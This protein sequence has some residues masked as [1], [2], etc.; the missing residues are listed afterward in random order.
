MTRK[1]PPHR[2]LLLTHAQVFLIVTIILLVI[3]LGSVVVLAYVNINTA[4]AFQ[5][6][7]VVT[8]LAN[9]QRKIIELH[10]ETNLVLRDRSTNV[11]LIEIKRASL[12]RHLEISE[13]EG[14]NNAKLI[15]TLRRIRY[16]LDQYDY[17][18]R[19]II[20]NPT[21]A[22]FRSSS[23]QFDSILGMLENE[24]QAL[25][26]N[27]ELRFFENIDDA[28]KQQRTSQ[29][30][31]ITIG[32][33]LL[34]FTVLF[35][36]S[37]R[38]SVSGEFQHAYDLLKEEVS[39]RRRAEEELRQQNEYFS[40]LH[41]TSLALMNR[42]DVSDLLE[43]IVSRAAQLMGTEDG[44]IYLMNA[45]KNVLERRVGV[46]LFSKSIG[47][48][49]KR[50]EGMAGQ[51]WQD[52]HSMVINDYPTWPYRAPTP[53][54]RENTIAAA[55]GAPLKSGSE[56]VGV[57]GLAFNRESGRIFSQSEVELLEGFAQLA[58]IALDN[59][60]LFAQADQRTMQIEA[61]YLADQELYKHLELDDVLKTL[62]D[63]AV[64]IL[65]IDKSVLIVWNDEKTMLYPKAAR[66]FRPE[67][68]ERMVFEPEQGLIGKVAMQKEP[69]VVKDTTS[70]TRVDWNITYPERIR[71]FM[72]VPIIVDDQVF[73]IFNVSYTEAQPFDEDDLR[74]VLALA[75]RGASAIKNASLYS[76]AQQAAML[77]E[78]QRLARELHDAVTQTLFSAGIIADV[79]PRLW[80]KDQD[81]ALKR[82]EELRELTRGALAEMRTLLWELRPTALSE[83]SL[84]ELLHQLGEVTVGRTRIPVSV[85]VKE[86]C[87]IPINVKIAFYRIAQEALN[88]IAKHA[89]ARHVKVD[90]QCAPDGV[91]LHIT[92][93][94]KGFDGKQLLPDN[95]GIRIMRERSEAVGADFNLESHVG[96]GTRIT[97]FWL[98][99]G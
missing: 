91:S 29:T 51:V 3:A 49:L 35:S 63:V 45:V 31:T 46:G 57:I 66:G 4:T 1:A 67:T 85:N 42:L 27:E 12:D 11:E 78:R 54:V 6:G 95:M 43:A 70:D 53:G 96:S 2:R 74:L 5:A 48:G 73:G 38:R 24:I 23:Y 92:D 60:Q 20:R 9:I 34:V 93:D 72:H 83:T 16:L 15:T 44:Y 32:G 41:E 55:M 7:Y 87:E 82:I 52:G 89:D 94:G 59:A 47:F 79:L 68:L 30:L 14:I 19:Q 65:H 99:T 33:L 71:S 84:S 25:Y 56:V 26:G 81:E 64:D 28:L 61:L 62:V 77:E 17:E 58:S 22:Q 8:D 36:M 88:N 76:Q 39:E 50:G 97:V 37:L 75:Q 40:A 18:T 86:L 80:L 90:M 98:P 10:M 21:E 13:A 69:V